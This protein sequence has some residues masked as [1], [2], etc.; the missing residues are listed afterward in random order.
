M[1]K[2]LKE[3][4]SC[5]IQHKE[6]LAATVTK[7]RI[8]NGINPPNDEQKQLLIDWRIELF[9]YLGEALF[10]DLAQSEKKFLDWGKKSGEIAVKIQLSL[11]TALDTTRFYR[12]TILDFI[13]KE[14]TKHGYTGQ[15]VMKAVEIIDPLL[16][17]VVYSFSVAY[18]DYNNHL[19]SMAREALE[20]LSVPV[21]RLTDSVG[22]LPLVGSIDTHRSKLIME[23]VLNECVEMKIDHLFIDL[24][25]VPVIDTMVAHNLFQ[26]ITSLKL[27]GVA[28]TLTGMRPELAQTVVS[29]GISFEGFSIAGSLHQA[30]QQ[31]KFLQNV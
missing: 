25:G 18:V 30:L 4:G 14:V 10:S 28:V 8:Q 3:L 12:T 17:K 5:I 16:D 22:I 13:S 11:D 6:E 7:N 29:L 23:I 15:T 24:S 27:L 20:E 1:D 9:H 21:V 31:K 19:L 26:V 2:E